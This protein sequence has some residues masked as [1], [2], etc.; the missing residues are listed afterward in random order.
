MKV[1]VRTTAPSGTFHRAGRAWTK[2]GTVLDQGD[3]TR[4]TWEILRAEPLI[5]IGPAPDDAEVAAA[6]ADVLKDAVRRAIAGLDN[7]GFGQDGTPLL[8]AVRKALPEGSAAITKK[9]VSDVWAELKA[10][11]AGQ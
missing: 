10:E 4:E 1:L 6:E 3:L 8:D 5:H 2:E 11:T 7:D 9:L